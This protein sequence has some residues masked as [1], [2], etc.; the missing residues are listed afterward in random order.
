MNMNPRSFVLGDVSDTGLEFVSGCWLRRIDLDFRANRG[1]VSV[2]PWPSHESSFLCR[3]GNGQQLN[4]TYHKPLEKE[5]RF[6]AP[7]QPF[8]QVR[9]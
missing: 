8:I 9:L 4:R 2:S 6:A 7:Y 1:R 3:I 5:A